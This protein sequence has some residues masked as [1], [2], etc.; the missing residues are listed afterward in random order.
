MSTLPKIIAVSF[1]GTVDSH[2]G[3]V[4]SDPQKEGL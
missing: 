2:Y 3:E 1:D 4:L